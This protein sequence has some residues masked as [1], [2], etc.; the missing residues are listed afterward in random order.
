M[1]DAFRFARLP[2]IWF[3]S[4]TL[5]KTLELAGGF[6]KNILLVTGET[7]F[8]GTPRGEQFMKN[9]RKGGIRFDLVKIAGEPETGKIDEA[10]GMFKDRPPDLVIAVGGGSV[11]DA[12]KAISAMIPVEGKTW[13]YLEGNP[14]MKSHPGTK[15]PFI[16]IPTTAGT[17]SEATKNAVLSTTM[18]VRLK[19]SLRHDNF[20]PEIAVVD[21]VLSTGCPRGVSA[22]SGLDALTQLLEAYLSTSASPMTDA[23]AYSGLAKAAAVIRPVISGKAGIKEWEGMAYASLLSGIVLANAGLGAVHGF[24]SVLGGSHKIPHGIICGTLLGAVTRANLEIIR[25]N[26]EHKKFAEKYVLA[27]RLFVSAQGK[28]DDYYLLALADA[29]DELIELSGIPRL[30]KFDVNK[31]EISS[32]ASRTG[33][34]NNPVTLSVNDLEKI[35]LSRL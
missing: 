7:S 3:G 6:G 25:G 35:L 16:A 34:K 19:R 18:P 29:L 8:T 4:G 33:I 10:A 31:D 9:A 26:P 2:V 27:A 30:G 17:G 15:V 20:I 21:P 14:E 32:I 28:S 24:A 13:D 11:I 22:P 5:G 12:G 23:L 1:V